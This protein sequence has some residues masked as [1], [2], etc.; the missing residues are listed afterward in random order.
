M[1]TAG[2]VAEFNPL[3]NGHALL[4]QKTR[5][6]GFSH[7]V[8]VM[9]GNYTQRG[10]PACLL[11]S[12]R[13]RAALLCGA[14]LVIELPLPWAVSSAENFASGAL[15]LLDALGCVDTLSFG[16]ECG[17]TRSLSECARK[18]IELDGSQIL[19]EKLRLGCSF[20]K[21]RSLALD[22]SAAAILENPNDTLAV[23]YIKAILRQKS[24]IMPMAISREG[25]GHDASETGSTASASAI[26][27]MLSSG[28]YEDAYSFMPKEAADIFSAEI[29]LRKGPFIDSKFET[30]ILAQIRRMSIEDFIKLPDVTEGLEQRVFQAAQNSCTL[31]ELYAAIKSKRYTMSRIRRIVLYA[32]LGIEKSAFMYMPPYLRVM[33]FNDRGIDL[34]RIAKTRARL[35]IYMRFADFKQS[36]N[37]SKLIYELECRSSDLY[38]LCLPN[39]LPCG[40][41]QKFSILR[42]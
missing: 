38:S 36:D 40:I 18:V 3:H 31:E 19:T 7:I 2:I 12:A 23:E 15:S 35:P 5:E 26:R 1:K 14:D 22:D 11:K 10:E 27:A 20:P 8:V 34:L 41:E 6:A 28:R 32:F 25:A 42:V 4:M 24:P 37:Y 39:I 13:V 21:A 30:L 9:S 33:G 17:E 16:S 29:S